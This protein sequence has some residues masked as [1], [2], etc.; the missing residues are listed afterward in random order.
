MSHQLA[1]YAATARLLDGRLVALRR[2]SAQDADTTLALHQHLTEFERYYRFFTLNRIDLEHLV[3]T[4]TE[5]SRDRYSLGAFDA[6]RLIGVAHYVVRDDPEAAEVAVVVAHDDHSLGVGTALLKHLAQVARA[7][8]ISR[9]IADILSENHLMLTVLFD[10]GWR[11]KPTYYGAIHHVEV[12]LPDVFE[13][14]P[15]GAHAIS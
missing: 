12:E 13:D 5:P 8:G 10:L 2:L 15:S 14:L 4:I 11:C 7:H 6:G 1:E 9:F 3:Q